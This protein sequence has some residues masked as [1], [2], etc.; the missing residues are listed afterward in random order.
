MNILA[1][2]VIKSSSST[3]K[4]KVISKS[5]IM[6]FPP[7]FSAP[8]QTLKTIGFPQAK[9]KIIS[10]YLPQQSY[11]S[12]KKKKT[13]T[14]ILKQLPSNQTNPNNNHILQ[15]KIT[16]RGSS[17][18]ISLKLSQDSQHN[19]SANYRSFKNHTW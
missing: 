2:E 13:F 1:L 6:S 16:P 17:A 15:N 3:T 18:S 19:L 10:L 9:S 4:R 14:C 12:L 5:T 11:F 7:I 8:K